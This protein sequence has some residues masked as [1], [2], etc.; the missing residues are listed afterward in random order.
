MKE[1]FEQVE[2]GD[3]RF[4]LM[5]FPEHLNEHTVTKEQLALVDEVTGERWILMNV[6]GR[7]VDWLIEKHVELNNNLF[8]LETETIRSRK[9]R[10][11]LWTRISL[12]VGLVV[13]AVE[14][15]IHWPFGR[16]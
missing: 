11:Y 8:H 14:L 3:R 2:A 15:V 1:S 4:N 9:F 10:E 13:L 7:K 5:K 6:F 12:V 16:L